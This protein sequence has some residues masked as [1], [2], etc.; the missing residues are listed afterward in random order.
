MA[1]LYAR[2]APEP[3]TMRLALFAIALATSCAAQ[4]ADPQP[5]RTVDVV[6]HDFGLNMPDPYRWMEGEGNAEFNAW[7]HAQGAASRARLDALPTLQGWRDRLT[8]A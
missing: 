8:A 4:A 1:A 2:P 5:A 3:A 7:L 6:D